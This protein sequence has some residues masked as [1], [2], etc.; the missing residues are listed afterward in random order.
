MKAEHTPGPWA[1][2]AED[3]VDND[4]L[5]IGIVAANGQNIANAN[6]FIVF[7]TDDGKYMP[8]Q[9]PDIDTVR[10]NASLMAAAP[11]LLE[12]LNW[13]IAEIN[14]ESPAVMNARKVIATAL[15]ANV[16]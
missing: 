16:F 7:Q 3:M 5:T 4:A 8:D 9:T 12:A 10:A 11:F 2:D 13:C 1:V 14:R 15:L 6:G